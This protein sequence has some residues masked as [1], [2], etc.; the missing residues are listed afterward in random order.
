MDENGGDALSAE[1]ASTKRDPKRR[2]SSETVVAELVELIRARVFRPGDRLREQ[3]LAERFGVS[4]GPV[5]EALRILEAKALVKIEPMRGASVASL[6]DEEALEAVEISAVLF[7]LGVRKA[8]GKTSPDMIAKFRTRVA[9]LADL[10]DMDVSARAY[11]RE[12]VRLGVDI[13]NVAASRRFESLVADIRL[14]APDIFG[15]LGFTTAELR[16]TATRKWAAMV[17]AI[18]AGDEDTAVSLAH[19]VY[20][21]SLNAGFKVM[22]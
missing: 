7:G 16:E 5:R 2:V 3:E 8:V 18:E 21:D 6:S 14:G 12:T 20:Y 15:P 11:Y 10:C 4:R 22:G 19:Q 13:F 9:R 1:T 17:D